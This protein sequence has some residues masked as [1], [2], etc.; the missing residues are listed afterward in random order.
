VTAAGPGS[1]LLLRTLR[2][3]ALEPDTLPRPPDVTDARARRPCDG[4]SSPPSPL[5]PP[6]AAASTLL[7]RRRPDDDALPLSVVA[8]APRDATSD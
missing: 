1:A 8:G 6:R 4:A 2:R 7:L 5:P 3:G